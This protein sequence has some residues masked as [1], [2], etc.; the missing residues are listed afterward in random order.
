METKNIHVGYAIIPIDS[1]NYQVSAKFFN[2]DEVLLKEVSKDVA[3]KDFNALLTFTD[4]E[5]AVKQQAEKIISNA[6]YKA[7]ATLLEKEIKIA[8]TL[9]TMTQP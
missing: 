2:D 1:K 4:E 7:M 9:L 5:F 6:M 8:S 3:M